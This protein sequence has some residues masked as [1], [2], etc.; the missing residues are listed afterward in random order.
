LKL[1]GGAL[2]V[3][4]FEEVV[5]V[6]A[7]PRVAACVLN[8]VRVRMEPVSMVDDTACFK[9]SIGPMFTAQEGFSALSNL[10][11]WGTGSALSREV[12]S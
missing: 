3:E 10:V 5:R 11:D 4:T 8:V 2:E 12:T 7:D 6:R 1:V 9:D